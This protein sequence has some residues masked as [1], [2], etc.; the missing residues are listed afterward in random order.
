[1]DTRRIQ[2]QNT[3]EDVQIEKVLLALYILRLHVYKNIYISDIHDDLY[4]KQKCIFLPFIS[5]RH[6][7]Y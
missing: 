5:A 2:I 4:Y 7:R 3:R 6:I 1:M